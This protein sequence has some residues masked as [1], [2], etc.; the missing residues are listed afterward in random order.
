MNSCEVKCEYMTLYGQ[1]GRQ[2]QA[3]PA[4]SVAA[5]RCGSQ[6]LRPA[7]CAGLEADR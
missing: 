4:C 5:A 1:Y 7:G 3:A 2:Q 6:L